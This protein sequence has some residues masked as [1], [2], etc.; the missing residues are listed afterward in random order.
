MGWRFWF[1]TYC[2][3]AIPFGIMFTAD[4]GIF[5]NLTVVQ[6]Y[7]CI[8]LK[9]KLTK[10]F[11]MLSGSRTLFLR[12]QL[13]ASLRLCFIVFLKNTEELKRRFGATNTEP[14]NKGHNAQNTSLQG[15]DFNNEPSNSNHPRR[16]LSGH[17]MPHVSAVWQ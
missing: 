2:E 5:P 15:Q 1:S 4:N 14:P 12:E 16:G 11:N 17:S 9:N 3:I 6:L 8:K 7:I 13:D 10:Y